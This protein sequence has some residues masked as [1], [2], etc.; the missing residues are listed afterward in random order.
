MSSDGVTDP[1]KTNLKISPGKNLLLRRNLEPLVVDGGG[2]DPRDCSGALAGASGASHEEL[3][4]TSSSTDDL[5]GLFKLNV[6]I[7]N[8]KSRAKSSRQCFL[9]MFIEHV[10]KIY[11]ILISKMTNV[12]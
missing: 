12:D 6:V 9:D 2:W 11:K 4:H 8:P 10:T 7:Y 1:L 3:L 5:D